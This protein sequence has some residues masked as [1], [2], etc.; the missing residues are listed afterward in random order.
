MVNNALVAL[1]SAMLGLCVL[2]PPAA[3]AELSNE[4]MIGLGL[5]TRPAYEGSSARLTELVPVLRYVGPMWFARSTQGVLEGGA[6]LELA[7]GLHAGAQLSYE[8]GRRSGDADFL[9]RHGVATIGRGASLGLHA[10][11]DT[12]LGPAPIT[13]LARL[14]RHTDADLGTQADLRL[15]V[16]VLRSGPLGVG[17]FTQATWADTRSNGAFYGITP[18]QSTVTGLPVFSAGSGWLSASAGLLWSFDVG[19]E[20]VAVGNLEARQLRGEA[21]GSP[22]VERR[23]SYAASAGLARRF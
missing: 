9:E 10:E 16:G 13:L 4:T 11:W 18:Q 15:S 22:L 6:R 3:Q 19:A 23:R 20:W 1:R 2:V 12:A 5:R 17:V 14:R 21:A 8:S 7:P